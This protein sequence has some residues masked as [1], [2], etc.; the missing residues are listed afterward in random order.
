MQSELDIIKNKVSQIEAERELQNIKD[1]ETLKKKITELDEAKNGK[2]KIRKAVSENVL[3]LENLKLE[4]D[5]AE[6]LIKKTE[7]GQAK[8]GAKSFEDWIDSPKVLELKQEKEILQ[9]KLDDLQKNKKDPKGKKKKGSVREFDK[10]EFLRISASNIQ[11]RIEEIEEL[12]QVNIA[13]KYSIILAEKRMI[14]SSNCYFALPKLEQDQQPWPVIDDRYQVVSFIGKGAFSEIFKVFDLDHGQYVILK[15][16]LI[17]PTKHNDKANFEK[18]IKREQDVL[19]N[20]SHP[21]IVGFIDSLIV[22]GLFCTVLEFCEGD[23]LD[24]YLKKNRRIPEK[25][26]RMIVRQILLTI[27]YL[28]SQCNKVIHYDL[29][30]QNII[31]TSDMLVKLIDF[32]LCKVLEE[33]M[34]D[35]ELTSQGTGTYWYL[36]PECFQETAQRQPV[37]ISTK[38]D[39]WS[40]GV[41]AYQLLYGK[42]PFG[43]GVSQE[44]IQREKLILQATH[45]DFPETPKVSLEI[46]DFIKKCLVYDVENRIDIFE[47]VQLFPKI[48]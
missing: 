34:S 8:I 24:T 45:V 48:N 3:L 23:D 15:L 30:P 47:A 37:K 20:L 19:K 21:G 29:K 35:I 10:D 6:L 27:R 25:S 2:S 38:V 33:D 28:N 46:K 36:S 4:N 43:H 16:H 13:R 31:F 39:V 18:H 26:V 40:I 1:F 9:S 41:I 44:K 32:G 12:E 7:I 42:K 14:D 11:K 22:N 5:F 17:D